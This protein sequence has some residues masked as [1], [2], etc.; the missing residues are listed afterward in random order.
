VNGEPQPRKFYGCSACRDR[1]DCKFFLWCDEELSVTAKNAWEEE[2]NK[3][4][5]NISL[6]KSFEK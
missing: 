3:F 6:D 2:K 4:A 5:P 1:K